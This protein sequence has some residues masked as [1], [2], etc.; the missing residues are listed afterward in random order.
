MKKILLIAMLL[1]SISSFAQDMTK[2]FPYKL[3]D[4]TEMYEMRKGE[5]RIVTANEKVFKKIMLLYGPCKC[6][7][8]TF[9]YRKDRYG[10]YEQWTISLPREKKEELILSFKN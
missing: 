5:L 10:Y 2:E 4:E 7:S 6:L 1:L 9:R 8:Y 3:A